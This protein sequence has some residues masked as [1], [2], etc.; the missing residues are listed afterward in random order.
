MDRPCKRQKVLKTA[1]LRCVRL[2]LSKTSLCPDVIDLILQYHVGQDWI[3]NENNYK[4][5]HV[6]K[7]KEVMEDLKV[8][9]SLLRNGFKWRFKHLPKYLQAAV[10]QDIHGSITT[11]WNKVNE[12]T[13]AL[14]LL[15]R[16]L[17][18][19]RDRGKIVTLPYVSSG[20]RFYTISYVFYCL[21]TVEFL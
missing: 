16:R 15:N 20:S 21:N 8:E 4:N 17:W 1:R 7:W 10:Y 9:T 13:S 6:T 12:V 2:L 3:E 5:E 19:L 18:S 14:E 11:T